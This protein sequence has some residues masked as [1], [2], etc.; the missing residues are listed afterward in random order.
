MNPTLPVI[1]LDPAAV[2]AAFA[3]P[4][5]SPDGV[6]ALYR[7]VHPE[8][9]RIAKL[10]DF[11]VCSSATWEAICKLVIE[12]DRRRNAELPFDKQFMAG[13]IWIG[14]GFSSRDHLGLALWEVLPVP[15][16]KIILSA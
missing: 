7:M 5:R 11:P 10:D 16:D 13:G 14:N 12:C 9:D 2:E 3:A 8:L 4:N 15:A 1:K 6:I